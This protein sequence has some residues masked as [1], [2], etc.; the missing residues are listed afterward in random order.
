MGTSEF[1]PSS[2]KEKKE[3]R[4][5]DEKEEKILSL[6]RR[7]YAS[8]SLREFEKESNKSS[9]KMLFLI[10]LMQGLILGILIGVFLS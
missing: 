4:I 5:L 10:G 3:K 8:E 9:L 1:N 2:R 7:L 6:T